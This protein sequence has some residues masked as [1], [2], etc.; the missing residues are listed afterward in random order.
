MNT[1]LKILVKLILLNILFIN[2]INSKTLPPGTGGE[3]DVPANVLIMLDV[4]GSMNNRTTVGINYGSQTQAVTPISNS[5]SILVH[6]SRRIT[7]IN[8]DT[9]VEE[10]I[11]SSRQRLEGNC[12]TR[13]LEKKVVYYDNKIYYYTNFR[14]ALIEYDVSNNRCRQIERTNAT[15]SHMFLDGD[16]LVLMNHRSRNYFV[17]DLTSVTTRSTQCSVQ[18]NSILERILK[19]GEN[20]NTP[21]DMLWFA[22]SILAL[23]IG[24]YLVRKEDSHNVKK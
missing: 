18:R 13:N 23:S 4:S 14:R 20:F 16:N 1:Y 12:N 24:I 2:P 7:Q 10:P 3:A 6:S 15:I 5:N 22:V 11:H 8:Q 17:K 9:N 19:L 21:E